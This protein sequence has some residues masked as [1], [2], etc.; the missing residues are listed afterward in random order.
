[1]LRA[2]APNRVEA[3]RLAEAERQAEARAER[4]AK[5]SVEAQSLAE[6]EIPDYVNVE[7]LPSSGGVALRDLA[8]ERWA[9]LPEVTQERTLPGCV[10]VATRAL[11]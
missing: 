6:R 9:A 10:G 2:K 11:K 1:M 8:S 3:E 4:Q 7:A 5:A